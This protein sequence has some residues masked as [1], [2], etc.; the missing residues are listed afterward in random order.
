MTASWITSS[1]VVPKPNPT[2]RPRYAPKMHQKCNK[3]APKS[4]RYGWEWKEEDYLI[5]FS[6]TEK[7]ENSNVS[8]FRAKTFFFQLIIT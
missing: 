5:W 2:F 1:E 4:T 3:N 8:G 7:M 6:L